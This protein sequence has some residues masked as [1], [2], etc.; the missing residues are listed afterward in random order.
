M[1]R[2]PET[3]YRPTTFNPR[4]AEYFVGDMDPEEFSTLQRERDEA[5]RSLHARNNRV[6]VSWAGSEPKSDAA[7]QQKWVEQAT[8]ELMGFQPTEQPTGRHLEEMVP[9]QGTVVDFGVSPVNKP[10]HNA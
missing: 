3:G 4:Q 7:S 2:T 8:R 6:A 1:N 5:V 9:V 10:R